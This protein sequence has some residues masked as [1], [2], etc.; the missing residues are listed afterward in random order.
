MLRAIEVAE[1]SNEANY[2]TTHRRFFV[3]VVGVGFVIVDIMGKRP[4]V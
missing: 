2:P 3:H 1:V 4:G